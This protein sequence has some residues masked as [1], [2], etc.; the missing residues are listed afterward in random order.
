MA[1]DKR[2]TVEAATGRVNE[3]ETMQIG[4]WMVGYLALRPSEG[5]KLE[6]VQESGKLSDLLDFVY[7]VFERR[8]IGDEVPKQEEFED[9]VGMDE[10]NAFLGFVNGLTPEQIE[11]MQ[12][13]GAPNSGK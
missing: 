4:P 3:S 10:I 9:T 7:P 1:I 5:R 2:R 13:A 6:T 12:S 11:D 8:L